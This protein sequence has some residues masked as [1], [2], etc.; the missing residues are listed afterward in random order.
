MHVLEKSTEFDRFL[1]EYREMDVVIQNA[2]GMYPHTVATFVSEQELTIE[3]LGPARTQEKALF[4]APPRHVYCCPIVDDV[5]AGSSHG[6]D[7]IERT[8]PNG[9]Y[10]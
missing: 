9:N 7:T 8:V 6:P 3:L 5:E 10:A 1:H 4:Q 2:I